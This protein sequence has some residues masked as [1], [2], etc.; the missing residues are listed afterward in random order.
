MSLYVKENL[1]VNIYAWMYEYPDMNTYVPCISASIE[2]TEGEG[3]TGLA[4]TEA[5]HDP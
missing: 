4:T 3:H 5:L 1:Y 2:D